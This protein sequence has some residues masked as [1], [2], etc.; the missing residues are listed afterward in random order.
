[1][2]IECDPFSHV[3]LSVMSSVSA[4]RDCGAGLEMAGE[5]RPESTEPNPITLPFW[6]AM[7]PLN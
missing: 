5:V 1:M 6:L 3:R 4:L 2:V 7:L